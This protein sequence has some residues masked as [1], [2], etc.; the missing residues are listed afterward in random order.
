[1]CFNGACLPHGHL[2]QGRTHMIL[3]LCIFVVASFGC[4]VFILCACDMAARCDIRMEEMEGT[5][6]GDG[7]V[8]GDILWR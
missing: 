6:Y 7:K 1:M 3:L 8:F 5:P 2:T 4:A